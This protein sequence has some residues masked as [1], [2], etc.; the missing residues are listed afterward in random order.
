MRRHECIYW[1]ATCQH[2]YLR[3]ARMQEGTPKPV[4]HR[5]ANEG[6]GGV[7]AQTAETF[8]AA[9]AAPAPA[10]AARP[11][12]HA[13]AGS[14]A[15]PRRI[16]AVAECCAPWPLA[17]HPQLPVAAGIDVQAR[18]AIH[19]GRGD[20]P[21]PGTH[22]HGGKFLSFGRTT[23]STS[24]ACLCDW[25]LR[26]AQ[27]A[28]P[29]PMERRSPSLHANLFTLTFLG[30]G[31]KWPGRRRNGPALP[32]PAGTRSAPRQDCKPPQVP[33]DGYR[34]DPARGR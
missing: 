1:S 30:V 14:C 11:A 5:C 4:K 3:S 9:A 21:L 18:Q 23:P 8:R 15:A 10:H 28:K 16:A 29:A 13:R 31:Q 19:L 6:L 24:A 26:V 27:R 7:Y 20:Q 12:G 34:N 25:W 17:Q 22:W 32:V 33:K 2:P